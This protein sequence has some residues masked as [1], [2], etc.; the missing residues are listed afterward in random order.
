LQTELDVQFLDKESGR[1]FVSTKEPSPGIWARAHVPGP[2]KGETASVEAISVLNWIRLGHPENA[3][4]LA[5]T[6]AIG[7]EES[8]DAPKGG[9][10]LAMEWYLQK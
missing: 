9:V 10:L 7:I 1:Y 8:Y 4:P 6:I 5:Q 2:G 3:S